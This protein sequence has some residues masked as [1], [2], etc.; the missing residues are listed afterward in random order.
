MVGEVLARL[1]GEGRLREFR[2]FDAYQRS[3]GPLFRARTMPESLNG[4]ALF[5]RASSG[6]VAHELVL[7]RAEILQKINAELGLDLVTDLR[8]KI[9]P[10][11][12]L[13]TAP[14]A[15]RPR[16]R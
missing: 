1:G 6:A 3:V 10:L 9:G 11:L 4:G 16:S 8:T 14:A 7:L 12:Q 15:A 5:V 2:V 13:G